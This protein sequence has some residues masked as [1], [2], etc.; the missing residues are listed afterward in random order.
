[1]NQIKTYMG[2]QGKLEKKFKDDLK[3]G[4]VTAVKQDLCK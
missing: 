1:V 2:V 4:K 3:D